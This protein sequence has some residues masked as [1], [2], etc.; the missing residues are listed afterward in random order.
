MLI[1]ILRSLL[2]YLTNVTYW[3]ITVGLK[4]KKKNQTR[5]QTFRTCV[6]RLL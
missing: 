1:D 4:K 5:L 3:E 6:E 2:R